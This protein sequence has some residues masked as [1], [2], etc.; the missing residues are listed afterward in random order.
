MFSVASVCSLTSTPI[1]SSNQLTAYVLA[2]PSSCKRHELSVT[3]APHTPLACTVSGTSVYFFL[4]MASKV[5][6]SD[7][8][9][10]RTVLALEV[11]VVIAAE[12]S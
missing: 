5:C 11:K 1:T 2:F 6:L 3:D 8:L 9:W 12:P 4:L 7:S 10:T